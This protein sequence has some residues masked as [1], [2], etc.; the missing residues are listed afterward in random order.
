MDDIPIPCIYGRTKGTR[1]KGSREEGRKV[2]S[3]S[4]AVGTN[5]PEG[6]FLP[7]ER[8]GREGR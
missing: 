1:R 3:V 2:A 6:Q 7:F 4:W 8:E 5:D